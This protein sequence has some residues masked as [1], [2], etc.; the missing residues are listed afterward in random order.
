MKNQG[1]K[2]ILKVPVIGD[3]AKAQNR[4]QPEVQLYVGTFEVY[5]ASRISSSPSIRYILVSLPP[6]FFVQKYKTSA[7]VTG[8]YRLKVKSAEGTYQDGVN[9]A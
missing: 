2:N 7:F 3:I 8:K 9:I 4:D 1:E 6:A 5:V